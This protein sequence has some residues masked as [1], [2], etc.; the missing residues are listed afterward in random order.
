M[1]S[2]RLKE[3]YNLVVNQQAN[4][5]E[6]RE[7][8]ALMALPEYEEQARDLISEAYEQSAAFDDIDQQT[9][10]SILEAIFQADRKNVVLLPRLMSTT[11]KWLAIAASLVLL[12]SFSIYLINRQ[13]HQSRNQVA[14]KNDIDPGSNKAILILAN[15]AKINLNKAAKGLISKQQGINVMKNANGALEYLS[16]GNGRSGS[17][18]AF[19]TL[20]TPVG[21]QYQV[22]LPDG[23]KV[24][25]NASS[26][27]RYPASFDHL[28]NRTVEL[29]GEGYFE[30]E[31]DKAHP[32]IV[33][34]G[35]H[36]VQVLGTHFDISSYSDDKTVKTT[37]LEGSVKISAIR[38]SIL[39]TGVLTP[40][41]QSVYDGIGVKISA[42][43]TDE[44]IAWHMGYFMF[45]REKLESILKKVSRWYDVQV[46]YQ[47]E[48]AK[49]IEFSGSV[50]RFSKVSELLKMLQLTNKVKFTIDAHRIYV[51]KQN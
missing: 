15:G 50:G 34:S 2:T 8:Q 23:T 32:F 29:S 1:E 18:I 22:N 21:G 31:K 38:G 7:M 11:K 13:A 35:N 19:N 14:F 5:E 12:A 3:L 41:Q 20:S 33:T 47:N 24:W 51:Y 48:E 43:D 39:H 49:G 27:L 36:Q 28:K 4:A 44:A 46:I 42:V 16:R 17:A 25:L 45:Q 9:R 6:Y 10:N 40:G 37:L 30:V 26:I